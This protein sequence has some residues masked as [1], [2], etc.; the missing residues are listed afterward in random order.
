[1]G[2]NFWGDRQRVFA[3]L[4]FLLVHTARAQ[5]NTILIIADDISP[6][7]FGCF[8]PATDTA[9]APNIRALA[10]AGI[11]FTKVWS[12]PV[13]SP[14]RAGILTGRYPFRTGV[15]GVI[16]GPTTPQI[17]T[18]EMTMAKLLKFHAPMKYRTACV[19]KW[20]LTTNQPLKRLYPNKMGF[21][22]Y[23]GNFNG[24]IPN[25]YR[26][27]RVK[28]GVLDTVTTYATTQTVND[29]IGWLDTLSPGKPFF[30]WLAFNAP[31]DPF[32]LPPSSLCNTSGLSGTAT[33]I[34]ANPKKYF[35]A[36]VEAMDTEIGRLFAYLQLHNLKDS[37]NILFIGDNGNQRE[38]AQNANPLQAKG[39]IYDYGVRVPMIVAGPAVQNG[40]RST[41]ALINTPD[42]FATMVEMCGFPLWKNAIPPNTTVDSRSF[43]PI[44]RNQ[45]V[46]PRPWI[47]SEIFSTPATPDN[48][49]TIRNV[50]YHLLRF[51]DGNE[52]FYNQTVDKEESQNLLLNPGSMTETDLVNYQLLC[53]SISTLTGISG[54]NA[55][56]IRNQVLLEVPTISPNP[57]NGW[58]SIQ[59]PESHQG[60]S[61]KVEILHSLGQ[62]VISFQEGESGA[63]LS[64]HPP[65]LYYLVIY[66][67]QTIFKQ[68]LLKM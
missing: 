38:V 56:P 10:K 20:H 30:L 32:H 45:T 35:K 25:Y 43:F 17:D 66:Q 61:T 46:I 33:D 48:G 47:F 11:R 22:F 16:T 18:S 55:V 62:K 27:P 4:F 64:G 34:Q 51:D 53:D 19:G 60:K 5:Q 39:T 63:D 40:D 6:D 37:T 42:L 9:T 31:H 1:M 67:G 28:N 26:Y 49:K 52:A 50:D 44:I 65:G 21:D 54:C 68:K 36:A 24:A 29:A 7:Y 57:T 13:C 15:G 8:S 12:A 23:S 3:L 59:L 58:V 2:I 14:A 41:D